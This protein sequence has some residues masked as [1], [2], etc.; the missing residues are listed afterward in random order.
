MV[1]PVGIIFI[2]DWHE[3]NIKEKQVAYEQQ[4]EV[5]RALSDTFDIHYNTIRTIRL[6]AISHAHVLLF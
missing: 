2:R 6:I 1:H 4:G 3:Y 5:D